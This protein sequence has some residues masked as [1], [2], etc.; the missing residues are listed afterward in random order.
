VAG[1]VRITKKGSSSQRELEFVGGAQ[2]D[3][4]TPHRRSESLGKGERDSEEE[5]GRRDGE[6]AIRIGKRFHPRTNK[7]ARQPH[8]NQVRRRT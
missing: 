4:R 5:F 8:R 2:K 6:K 3:E 1:N 7:R